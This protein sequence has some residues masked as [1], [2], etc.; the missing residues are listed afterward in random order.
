MNNELSFGQRVDPENG[1]VECWFTWGALDEIKSMDLYNKVIV[2]FGA[3][4]GDIW[5]SKRCKMLHIVERNKEWLGKCVEEQVNYKADNILY[6]YI[7]VNDCCG[8]DKEY[9]KILDRI[10]PDVVIN[11]D[12]YRFEV[13]EKSLTLKRPLVLITDNWMQDYVF[14]CPKGDGLLKNFEQK[15]FPQLDHTNHEGN[16][17]KTAIH[18]IK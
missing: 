13:I 8:M 7:E 11:D 6:H 1:L 3:G 18:F 14:L 15:I 4:L 2:M 10:I 16:C 17:W 9:L 5:L 12:A